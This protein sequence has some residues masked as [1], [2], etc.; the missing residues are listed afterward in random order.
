MPINVMWH[1]SSVTTIDRLQR[2]VLVGIQGPRDRGLV[3]DY[4]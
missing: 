1:D 2:S 3:F 4:R